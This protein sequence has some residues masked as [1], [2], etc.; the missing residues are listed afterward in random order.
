M[1]TLEKGKTK[2]Y[3]DR[4]LATHSGY[5]CATIM[6]PQTKREVAQPTLQPGQKVNIEELH[7]R[8]RHI[9]E[10]STQK[11]AKHYGVHL[12]GKL[13]PCEDCALAKAKQKSVSKVTPESASNIKGERL[14]M[15]IS[16]ICSVSYGGA[17]FWILIV[18]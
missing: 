17:K 15:D 13:E 9:S 5:V 10:N 4:L 16:S 12:N 8:L 14:Y 7:E 11:T 6:E 3:F 1:V 18:D 2:I